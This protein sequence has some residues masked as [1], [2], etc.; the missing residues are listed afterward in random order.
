MID[1]TMTDN[2]GC[3]EFKYDNAD[4]VTYAVNAVK[5]LYFD[6]QDITFINELGNGIDVEVFIHP[7]AILENKGA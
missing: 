2:E 1:F 7:E 6:N 3:F 4:G 5:E